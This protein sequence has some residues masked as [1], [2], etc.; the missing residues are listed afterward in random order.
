MLSM[1]D[2]TTVSLSLLLTL[3]W[4]WNS[5]SGG[6]RV[7]YIGGEWPDKEL[8]RDSHGKGHSAYARTTQK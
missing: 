7:L 3:G 6:L 4:L 1:K 2:S 5:G 8:D